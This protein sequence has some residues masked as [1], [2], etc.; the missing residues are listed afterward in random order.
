LL[1]IKS[2]QNFYFLSDVG[3]IK[4]R[5]IHEKNIHE[6]KATSFSFFFFSMGRE[7]FGLAP[8]LIFTKGNDIFSYLFKN[9]FNFKHMK[10][11]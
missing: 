2:E 4:C 8:Q 6:G 11:N 9:I 3:T 7:K 1:Q 10:Y 5:Q